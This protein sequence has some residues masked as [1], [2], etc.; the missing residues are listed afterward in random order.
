MN[1][2]ELRELRGCFSRPVQRVPEDGAHRRDHRLDR[3]SAAKKIEPLRS[4]PLRTPRSPR[5]LSSSRPSVYR[6][7]VRTDE[8]T[9]SIERSPPRRLNLC[10]LRELRGC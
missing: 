9:A 8:T 2:C 3:E 4:P 5:L 7:M 10:E 1:L 6:W